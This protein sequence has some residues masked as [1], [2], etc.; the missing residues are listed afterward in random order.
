MEIDGIHKTDYSDPVIENEEY[1]PGVK[2]KDILEE[3]EKR[4]LNVKRTQKDL[5]IRIS[6]Q[7]YNTHWRSYLQKKYPARFG[8][9]VGDS[10]SKR[11]K[12]KAKKAKAIREFDDFLSTAEIECMEEDCHY[13]V[14][15]QYETSRGIPKIRK[16]CHYCAS[17]AAGISAGNFEAYAQQLRK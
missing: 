9:A 7:V 16:R 2:F 14:K 12:A 13:M 8:T 1:A 5:D 6:H 10:R 15:I 4:D 3:L 11:A 17:K